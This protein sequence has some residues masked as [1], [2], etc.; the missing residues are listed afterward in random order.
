MKIPDSIFTGQNSTFDDFVVYVFGK[1]VYA[2]GKDIGSERKKMG[3]PVL[4]KGA[5]INAATIHRALAPY[6]F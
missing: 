5:W 3:N 2:I 1:S 4:G 6:A